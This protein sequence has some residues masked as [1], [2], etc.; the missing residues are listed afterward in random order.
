MAARIADAHVVVGK[1]GGLTATEC[2]VAR[3]PMVVVGAAGG[4]ETLNARW[5]VENGFA[6]AAPPRRVGPVLAALRRSGALAAM[7]DRARFLARPDAAA[8]V[9]R[10]ALALA[11]SRLCAAA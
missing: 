1:P 3:R 5:L 7:A 4:Q 2:L 10:V 9:V 8:Q 6:R 11:Q